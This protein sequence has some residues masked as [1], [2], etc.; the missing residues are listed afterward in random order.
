ME[1]IILLVVVLVAA[2]VSSMAG[3]IAAIIVL[4][5]YLQKQSIKDQPVIHKKNKV[6]PSVVDDKNSEDAKDETIEGL[7][8]K[9]V[10][11]LQLLEHDSGEEKQGYGPTHKPYKHNTHLWESHDDK[12]NYYAPDV[13]ASYAWA[14]P[15]VDKQHVSEFD[16]DMHNGELFQKIYP[17]MG[18]CGDTAIANRMKYMGMQPQVS[19]AIRASFNKHTMQP[20]LEEEL[21]AH[22]DREWWASDFLDYDF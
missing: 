19:K 14:N 15:H 18:C 1:Q 3:V 10:K 21:R 12:H 13:D 5:I 16:I 4:Y 7:Q 9:L 8:N 11:Q 17:R 2:Y 6:E 20:Y 22:A